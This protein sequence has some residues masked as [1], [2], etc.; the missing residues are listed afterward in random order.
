MPK[1]NIDIPH[2]QTATY[3]LEAETWQDAVEQASD[4]A[5]KEGLET[6]GTV[7]VYDKHHEPVDTWA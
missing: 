5:D 7:R 4:L 6:T 1:F 2:I 3:A